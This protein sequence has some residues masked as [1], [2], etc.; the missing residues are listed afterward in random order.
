MKTLGHNLIAAINA[1]DKDSY[2]EISS[3]TL[4]DPDRSTEDLIIRKDLYRKLS[5][6]AREVVEIVTERP[7]KFVLFAKNNSSSYLKFRTSKYKLKQIYNKNDKNKFHPA[8][9]KRLQDKNI[10]R[11]FFQKFFGWNNQ[12]W[13]RVQQEIKEFCF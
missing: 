13:L 12:T 3:I 6:E 8:L 5:P 7:M 11:G 9:E 4:I 1:M 2:I 10:I